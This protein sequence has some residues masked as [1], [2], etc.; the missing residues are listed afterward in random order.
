[1]TAASGSRVKLYYA[2]EDADGVIQPT[3]STPEW[4]PLRFA[5]DSI[6]RSTEQVDS[7]EINQERQR[8]VSEQGTY[9]VAGT[10]RGEIYYGAFDD[11]FAALLQ[12][13]W[14]TD[15]SLIVGSTQQ[16]LAILKVHED[17]NVAYL[18]RGCEVNEGRLQL[19]LNRPAVMEFGVIGLSEEKYTIPGGSTYNAVT[20]TKM[21]VTNK[22]SFT[23]TIGPID[24]AV[25]YTINISNGMNPLSV[26]FQRPA[27]AI[28]NG[29]LTVDGTLTALFPDEDLYDEFL[30][31]D[32]VSHATVIQD[33]AGNEYTITLPSAKYTQA[34]KPTP[35]PT[36]LQP[37]FTFAAG[38]DGTTTIQLDRAAA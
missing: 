3:E 19:S 24:Y 35:G 13:S 21:M 9:S 36:A 30:D 5:T 7:E 2:L 28:E 22:G 1:M 18:Y 20:T 27:Y 16:R 29:L 8:V 6:E 26:L 15:D 34:S 11:I 23:D 10:V 33:V 31:E 14:A 32:E 17:L 37:T 4:T 38:F 12:N 25:E